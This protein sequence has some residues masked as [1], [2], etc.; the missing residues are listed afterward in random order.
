MHQNLKKN[1]EKLITRRQNDVKDEADE[2]FGKAN[3]RTVLLLFCNF[4]EAKQRMN[5]D[6][7]YND[8]DSNGI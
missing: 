7:P 8:G 2:V 4:L 1:S 5:Q 6:L 3:T